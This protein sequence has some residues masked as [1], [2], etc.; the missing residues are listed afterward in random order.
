[1]TKDASWGL[2]EHV[3]VDEKIAWYEISDGLSQRTSASKTLLPA[4]QVYVDSL[5]A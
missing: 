1:M 4:A 3:F 2:S 5:R